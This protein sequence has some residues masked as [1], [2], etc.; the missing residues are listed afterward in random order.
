MTKYR[1]EDLGDKKQFI[2]EA[3]QVVFYDDLG[4]QVDV[5]DYED[6][7]ST[8]DIG[9]IDD[10]SYSFQDLDPGTKFEFED[11]VY[12][13]IDPVIDVETRFQG[14]A[15]VVENRKSIRPVGDLASFDPKDI[16]RIVE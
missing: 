13:K 8:Y 4:Q 3:I 5:I 16:V 9:V 10:N 7:S 6:L 14:E 12:L 15:I 1:V 11:V 2:A